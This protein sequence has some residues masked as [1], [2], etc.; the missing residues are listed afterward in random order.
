MMV[1]EVLQI[2]SWLVQLVPHLLDLREAA[3]TNDPGQE[4]ASARR[5]IRAI[6]RQETLDAIAEDAGKPVFI[7][8]PFPKEDPWSP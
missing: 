4:L 1:S 2:L 8:D 5:L 7:N 3:K 6:K